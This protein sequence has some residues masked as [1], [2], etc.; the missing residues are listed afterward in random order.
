M[1][2][3]HSQTYQELHPSPRLGISQSEVGP[4]AGAGGGSP[5]PCLALTGPVEHMGRHIDRHTLTMHSQLTLPDTVKGAEDISH[6]SFAPPRWGR[7]LHLGLRPAHIHQRGHRRPSIG[8][9]KGS[10]SRQCT[11]VPQLDDL[12]RPSRPDL[13]RCRSFE[14]R[15][16]VE[17]TSTS[18]CQA[19]PPRRLPLCVRP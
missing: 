9:S 12:R 3:S 15:Y 8:Q 2:E 17:E 4:Y 6:A 19:L 5:L 10:P 13:L 18:W 11:A 7:R 16:P 14:F 1:G